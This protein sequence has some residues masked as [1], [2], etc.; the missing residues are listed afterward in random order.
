MVRPG[1]LKH[2]H[3][4]VSKG[5]GLSELWVLMSGILG[6]ELSLVGGFEETQD[7]DLQIFRSLDSVYHQQSSGSCRSK[8]RI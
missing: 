4:Q 2:R 1:G 3:P 7:P 5:V 8:L 6:L